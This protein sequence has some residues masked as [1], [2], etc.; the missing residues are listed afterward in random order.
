[1]DK[2]EQKPPQPIVA[3]IRKIVRVARKRKKDK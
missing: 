1:M 2:K 3:T